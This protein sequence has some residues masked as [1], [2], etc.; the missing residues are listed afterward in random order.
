MSVVYKWSTLFLAVI[1]SLM[2][3]EYNRM[4]REVEALKDTVDY[5]ADSHNE[6]VV[7]VNENLKS[8]QDR[9]RIKIEDVIQANHYTYLPTAPTD[10]L[11]RIVV[12]YAE[13]YKVPVNLV[14][15]VMTVESAFNPR[16]VSG[17]GATG[18]LQLMP[19]TAAEIARELSVKEYDLF[20]LDINIRF[21]TY[22]LH[23]MLQAFGGDIE[24]AVK[25]YNTGAA[26]VSKERYVDETVA[27]HK[28]VMAMYNWLEGQT[29]QCDR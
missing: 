4:C 6:V 10:N 19:S 25:A 20:D 16:A 14:L 27:Y 3:A 24:K 18:L 29:T 21:G 23:K 12:K 15:S 22:Y 8:K 5:L 17:T 28:S 1:V 9:V 26:N 7:I 13:R 11:A 2:L